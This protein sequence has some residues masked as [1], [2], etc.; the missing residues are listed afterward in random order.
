MLFTFRLIGTD[1]QPFF[2]DFEIREDHTFYDLHTAIQ[3]EL[4]YDRKQLASFY[5]ANNSWEKGLEINLVDMTQDTFTPVIT[6]DQTK[7]HELITEKDQR[8]L[9]VF[10][11]FSNRAFFIELL[12]ITQPVEGMPYP[13]CI[14]GRGMPPEQIM[15][16]GTEEA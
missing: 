14:S 9:Y 7:L 4:G 1:K 3:N 10:D 8:L 5:L 6:M 15:I 11:F 12:S 13:R 16:E 2:R